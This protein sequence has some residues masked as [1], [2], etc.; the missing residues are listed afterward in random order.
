MSSLVLADRCQETTTTTGTGTLTLAGAVAGYQSFAAIGNG[1]T[2]YYTITDGT[3]WEVGIGTYTLSG[4][5]LARTTVL[6]S[7]NS[8]SAVSFGAGTKTVFGTLP[9]EKAVT[10]DNLATPPAIGGTTPAAGKFS[11]LISVGNLGLG[12]TPDYGTS[13]KVMTSGGPGNPPAWVGHPIF[14]VYNSGGSALNNGAYT[15]VN[16]DTKNFDTDNIWSTTNN[17]TYPTPPGYYQFNCH[18][19]YTAT[20]SVAQVVLALYKNGS[21]VTYTN[22]VGNTTSGSSINLSTIEYANG[23]DYFEIFCYISGSGTLAVQGG[24]QSRLSA[25]LLRRT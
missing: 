18:L 12:A 1:N 10:A 5:T 14:N 8:G 21:F 20:V 25:A 13:G 6:A 23:T 7:S 11:T 24:Q 16:F 22:I 15:K 9:A 17:Q 2:T 4:T 3:N 19:V